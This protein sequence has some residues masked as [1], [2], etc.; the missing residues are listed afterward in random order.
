VIALGAGGVLES[1]REGETGVYYERAEADILAD[2][3]EAFDPLAIDPAACV[4]A[5]KR[6]GTRDFQAQ[7]RSI[8]SEAVA[9]ERSPKTREMRRIRAGILRAA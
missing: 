4:A 9:A 5:A 3:V 2:A 1:V 7:L 6:F 8:V